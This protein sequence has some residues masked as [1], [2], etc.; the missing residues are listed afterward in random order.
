[1]LDLCRGAANK[2]KPMR[3]K[4][5]IN[6]DIDS[7][8]ESGNF[9]SLRH[10]RREGR[11]LTQ[12]CQKEEA[13]FSS[14]RML[15]LSS[16]DYLGLANDSKL[17]H[18]FMNLPETEASLLTSSSSRL[19]TGNFQEYDAFEKQLSED[20]GKSALI[21]NCGYHANSGILPALADDKTLILADKFVHASLI[22]GIRL[23][24]A[25][26][27]RFKHNNLDQLEQLIEKYR[28]EYETI[29][30]VVESVYS[31]DGDVADL[32][33]LVKIKEMLGKSSGQSCSTANTDMKT[34][35]ECGCDIL[36]YVDEAHGVGVRGDRGLGLA[37]ETGCLQDIDILIGTLGKALASN[38]AF[39]ICSQEVRD[40]LINKMRPFIFT[41]A[42][43]PFNIAWSLFVWN[44]MKGMVQERKHLIEL[45]S[46]LR[47]AIQAFTGGTS[48][49]T[50][51]SIG[52]SDATNRERE[53]SASAKELVTQIVPLL[54][55]ESADA[56]KL[57]EHL[58]RK[59]FFVLP[60][61]PP[62]V[63]VGT[64]RLRF[65]L[66]A[67]MTTAEIDSLINA[68]EEIYRQR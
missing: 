68:I 13:E 4:E 50:T 51:N 52:T 15:N 29:F 19:L 21:F 32:K 57:A 42:L 43:P 1:M 62:T 17:R 63:P 2:V 59:G 10:L 53:K 40:Y 3:F 45:S 44:K 31:M 16:N 64:A 49:N 30:I 65:S 34:H 54:V 35:T 55:G 7:L 60:I 18:E 41:T 8:K 47:S 56:V 36:L 20:Y 37:E 48:Y 14:V 61:R 25:R 26:C 28:T 23:C 5:R 27:I 58:Q 9:R 39:A 66:T 22:D 24:S 6:K 46:K 67:D 38:G 11:Y 12:L 33:R